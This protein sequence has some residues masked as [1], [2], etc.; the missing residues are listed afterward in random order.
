MTGVTTAEFLTALVF[1]ALGFLLVR[2]GSHLVGVLLI[3][4]ASLSIASSGPAQW[5]EKKTNALVSTLI[6]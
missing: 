2:R 3:V 1:G 5:V 6:S 4:V